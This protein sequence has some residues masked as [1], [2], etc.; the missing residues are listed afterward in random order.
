[1]IAYRGWVEDAGLTLFRSFD[2]I[3]GEDRFTYDYTAVIPVKMSGRSAS[4]RR[5][6]S[7]CNL[8]RGGGGASETPPTSRSDARSARAL[9][10]LW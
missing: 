8:R 6:S 1:V 10:K 3:Q 9:R 2:L 7:C 5:G 4:R